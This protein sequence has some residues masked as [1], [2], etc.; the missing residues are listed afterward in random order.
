MQF[1]SFPFA[2]RRFGSGH[3]AYLNPK[4]SIHGICIGMNARG[5]LR[6]EYIFQKSN[7]GWQRKPYKI[8]YNPRS[9]GQ[10]TMRSKFAA[11]VAWAKSLTGADKQIYID[12]V[13]QPWKLA[14]YPHSSFSGRSWFNWAISDYMATH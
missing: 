13:A 6:K 4:K 10:T 11:A 3:S 7:G 5:S 8:P 9:V 12:L 1:D 14:G 2:T